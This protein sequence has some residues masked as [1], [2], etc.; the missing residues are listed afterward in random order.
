MQA[1]AEVEQS[2]QRRFV[3]LEEQED[4]VTCCSCVATLLEKPCFDLR[5][6]YFV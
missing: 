1:V 4:L 2:A 6:R 3:S 5:A